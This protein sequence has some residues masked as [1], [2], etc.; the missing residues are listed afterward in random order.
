MYAACQ[1]VGGKSLLAKVIV[2]PD[3]DMNARDVGS[4]TS[5]EGWAGHQ[6]ITTGRVRAQMDARSGRPVPPQF[7]QDDEGA[8]DPG[9]WGMSYGHENGPI[10]H[11]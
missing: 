3:T 11:L 7:D 6:Y 5:A 9:R 8:C 1:G 2:T 10:W 4:A